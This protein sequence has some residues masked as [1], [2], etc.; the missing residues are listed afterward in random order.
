MTTE[1]LFFSVCPL[2][3]KMAVGA[4]PALV[5]SRADTWPPRPHSEQGGHLEEGVHLEDGVHLEEDGVHLGDGVLQ[6]QV[7]LQVEL[8]APCANSGAYL[9]HI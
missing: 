2:T 1:T 9:K 5:W 4:A 6:V 8:L 3:W 7:G